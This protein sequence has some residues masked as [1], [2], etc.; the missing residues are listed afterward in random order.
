MYNDVLDNRDLTLKEQSMWVTGYLRNI[1][2]SWNDIMRLSLPRLS[3]ESFVMDTLLFVD[4]GEEV[5][6]LLSTRRV[7][8]IVYGVLAL[9]GLVSTIVAWVRTR[10]SESGLSEIEPDKQQ[11]IDIQMGLL[12][13]AMLILLEPT[14][15]ICLVSD[16]RVLYFFSYLLYISGGLSFLVTIS[17]PDHS[18]STTFISLIVHALPYLIA[19]WKVRSYQLN[20]NTRTVIR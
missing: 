11:H 17:D 20:N 2:N 15:A 6:L 1:K 9:A 14:L 10:A 19:A 7:C 16:S 3:L 12:L 18:A 5:Q 8:K 4:D 13:S